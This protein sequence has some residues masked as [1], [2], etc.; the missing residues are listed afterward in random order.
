[1]TSSAH[2]RG[3]VIA[4][5]L[6]ALALALAFV[7]LS[8]NKTAAP[9]SAHTV[10][11]LK[12]R[13]LAAGTAHKAATA[14]PA[15][16]AMGVKATAATRKVAKPK[17][18]KPKPADPN[19][20]AALNVG[21]PRAIAQALATSPVAVIQLTSPEDSVATLALGEAKAGA[22]LAHASFVELDVDHDSTAVRAL[23]KLFGAV[24]VAPATFVYQRPGTLYMTLQ[25]FNDR[26]VVQQAATNAAQTATGAA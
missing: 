8:M 5:G 9:A 22:T 1:V 11:S 18:V 26:T 24:P 15:K 19:L 21:L 14:A 17:V 16:T 6:A 7:T 10:L 12:A 23:T 20:L 25:G 4:G 13:H 2:L 3:I